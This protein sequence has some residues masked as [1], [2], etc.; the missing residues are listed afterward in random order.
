MLSIDSRREVKINPSRTPLLSLYIR[1]MKF[2]FH[3][4]N[5]NRRIAAGTIE[6]S[7]LKGF[8][9]EFSSEENLDNMTELFS[10]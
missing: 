7:G 10:T 5:L 2:S 9:V 3:S 1:F 8:P 4:S 6:W